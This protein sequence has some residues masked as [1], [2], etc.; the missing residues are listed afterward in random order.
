MNKTHNLDIHMYSLQDL[1]NLFE[2]TYDIDVENG[3]NEIYVA[4]FS[5]DK[6]SDTVFYTK[7]IDGPFGILPFAFTISK[8]WQF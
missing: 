5:H 8:I 2:L 1:L 4:A 7:H 6:N 3:M